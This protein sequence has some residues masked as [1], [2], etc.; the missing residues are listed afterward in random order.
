[1][2]WS[3]IVVDILLGNI[4]GIALW[5][6]VEPAHIWVS[7]FAHDFTNDWLCTGCVWLMGNP[8]GFKLNTEL[9]LFPSHDLLI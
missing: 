6:V 7:N 5:F 2:L 9:V 4:L 8:A 3:S 1:M